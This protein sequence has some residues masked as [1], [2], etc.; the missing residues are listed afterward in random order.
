MGLLGLFKGKKKDNP[1]P[2]QE[3]PDP[4]K[5]SDPGKPTA[6]TVD[7]VSVIAID[8]PFLITKEKK[9]CFSGSY[10]IRQSYDS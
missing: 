1:K 4:N 10:N 3:E 8:D 7:L 9:N 2:V 6:D 5:L